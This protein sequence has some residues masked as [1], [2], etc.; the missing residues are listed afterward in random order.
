MNKDDDDSLAIL[1]GTSFT[2]AV[3]VNYTREKTGDTMLARA[4]S[5]RAQAVGH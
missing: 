4:F 5:R 2:V 1:P 3:T